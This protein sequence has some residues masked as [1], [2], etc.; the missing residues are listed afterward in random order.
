MAGDVPTSRKAVLLA[1]FIA[2]GEC[3]FSRCHE[4]QTVGSVG[5]K[6]STIQDESRTAC[7]GFLFG[8]DMG[9]ISVCIVLLRMPSI[10]IWLDRVAL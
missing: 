2:F 3:D 6:P 7:L 1:V 8:Y 9:V 10:P 4:S 5:G